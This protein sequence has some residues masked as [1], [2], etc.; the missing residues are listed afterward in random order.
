MR[1]LI[2]AFLLSASLLFGADATGKWNG[3]IAVT[4]SDG[5]QRT[6]P[7]LLILKQEGTKITGTGGP[8]I[9]ERHDILEG[10][11]DGAS[12]TLK[13]EAGV[14][15]ISLKLALNG[16]ELN[17]DGSRERPDGQKQTAKVTTKRE[18]Q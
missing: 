12:V 8:D 4:T 10:K 15:P 14:A 17:G 11:I 9:G 5:E 1:Y 13:I 3:T 16:D 7:I 6:M 2:L 18:Q